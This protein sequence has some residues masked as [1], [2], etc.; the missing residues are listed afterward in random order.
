MS[1]INLAKLYAVLRA[2]AC[3]RPCAPLFGQ[4]SIL[5]MHA[6]D[7]GHLVATGTRKLRSW[8]A[9]RD[10]GSCQTPRD[11]SIPVQAA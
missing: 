11:R 4:L 6:G 8:H 2:A 1:Q 7:L 5:D 9:G 10:L 3:K